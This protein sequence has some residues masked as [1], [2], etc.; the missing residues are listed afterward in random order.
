MVIGKLINDDEHKYPRKTY[1]DILKRL[2]QRIDNS[3]GIRA[4]LNLCS[5]ILK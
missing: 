4:A 1:N 5:I 3:K 2:Q